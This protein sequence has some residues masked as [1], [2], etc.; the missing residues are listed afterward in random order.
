MT[1]IIEKKRDKCALS[2][3]EIEFFV[4]GVTDRSIPDYQI[5]ALLMAIVLNGMNRQETLLL[6]DAMAKSGDMLDLS[7]LPHTADKHSTGGVGDKTSLIAV[8][9][10]AA[11][12]CTVAKMSGRGLYRR[13]GR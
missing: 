4:A 1:E 8:P 12:G 5:S 6:T 11:L 13:H 7:A 10:A 3:K 2:K 9:A